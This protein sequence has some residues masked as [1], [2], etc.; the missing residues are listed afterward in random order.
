MEEDK[1]STP[2]EELVY[3]IID[4]VEDFWKDFCPVNYCGKKIMSLSNFYRYSLLHSDETMEEILTDLLSVKGVSR[5]RNIHLY[6]LLFTT[7][8]YNRKHDED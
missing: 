7:K 6:F 3:Q 8:V 2:T 1:L 4:T 5:L